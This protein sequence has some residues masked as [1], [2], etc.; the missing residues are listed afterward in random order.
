MEY[1]AQER[2]TGRVVRGVACYHLEAGGCKLGDL[3][4]PLC[5]A[6]LCE[7]VR[8]LLLAAAGTDLVGP[9]TDDFCGSLEVLRA[10]VAG[11]RDDGLTAVAALEDRLRALSARLDGLEARAAIGAGR[12]R[13]A[14]VLQR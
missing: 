5:V 13:R 6:Y 1:S 2:S 11:R 12:Q 10:I 14:R 7:P 8:E 3:K 9:E 4:G